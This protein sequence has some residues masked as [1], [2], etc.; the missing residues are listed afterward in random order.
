MINFGS[1]KSCLAK[2]KNIELLES[3]NAYLK[4]IVDRLLAKNGVPL[5]KEKE[6]IEPPTEEDKILVNGGEIIGG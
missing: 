4:K 6:E 1:C 2:D 5:K 3:H